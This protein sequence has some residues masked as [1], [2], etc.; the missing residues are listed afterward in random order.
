MRAD[1]AEQIPHGTGIPPSPGT[2]SSF[3]A[4]CDSVRACEA[5]DGLGAIAGS[6]VELVIWQRA[7]PTDFGDW[8]ERIDA[9]LLPNIRVLLRP[10]DLSR[11]LVPLLNDCGLPEGPKRYLLLRDV[12]QLV[13]AFARIART[14]L[15]DLRLE[16]VSGDACRRFHRDCVEARLLTT[17]RGPATEW[18]R[19][20]H[21]KA[22][23]ED[24]TA[25]EGPIERLRRYD[26]AIFKGSC[27]EA[28]SGIVHRSPPISGT[29]LTRLLLCLNQP[30]ATSPRP[31]P[32]DPGHAAPRP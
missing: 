12:E 2:P 19:P 8:L 6:D 17:Y 14:D 22:A 26:V 24:Q 30:S 21:A 20:D 7:L 32:K 29:G 27:A 28:A 10:A 5:A 23:L 31:W 11:A 15:V 16:S 1:Q 9:R 13:S 3:R 25:F 4:A 18:I